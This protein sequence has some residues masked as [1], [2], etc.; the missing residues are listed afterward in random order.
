[1]A[2]VM[3]SDVVWSAVQNTKILNLQCKTEQAVSRHTGEAGNDKLLAFCLKVAA[4]SFS[5]FFFPLT[6]PLIDWSFPLQLASLKKKK[7]KVHGDKIT[8]YGIFGNINIKRW[9]RYQLSSHEAVDRLVTMAPSAAVFQYLID[10]AVHDE[11]RG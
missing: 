7:V 10:M 8:I 11:F 9:P 3:S 5:D 2:K 6:N 1:M 4:D